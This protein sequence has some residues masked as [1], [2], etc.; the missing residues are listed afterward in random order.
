MEALGAA[1]RCRVGGV[2]TEVPAD[3]RRRTVRFAD[4]EAAVTAISWGDVASAYRSTGIGD[5]V[6]YAALPGAAG[7]LASVAEAV[8]PLVRGAGVQRL[9]KRVVG[10]LPGPTSAAR[11]KDGGQLWCEV[12]GPEGGRATGTM[13]TPNGYDLTA[14]AVVTIAR[15]VLAGDVVPGAHT[16]SSALGSGFAG[17]LAGV[18]VQ[19]G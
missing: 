11:A 12:T 17:E 1:S 13:S 6:V 7:T 15:R 18:R 10:R 2:I 8:G 4:R 16:P 3:R 19:I 5:I 9:L 14:D